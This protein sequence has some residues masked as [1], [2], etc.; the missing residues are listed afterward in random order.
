MR[1]ILFFIFGTLLTAILCSCATPPAKNTKFNLGSDDPY[2]QGQNL[3]EAIAHGSYSAAYRLMERGAPLNCQDKKDEWTPLT[4]AIYYHRWSIARV[5]IRAGANVNLADS[6]NRT[7][8][9]WSAMRNSLTTAQLLVEYGADI[10]AVDIGGRTALQYAI[11]YDNDSLAA[12]LA[13][14]GRIPSQ[15][16]LKEEQLARIQKEREKEAQKA[17][18]L[19]MYKKAYDLTPSKDSDAP[20]AL[21]S[22]PLNVENKSDM[23][24]INNNQATENKTDIKD[25]SNDKPIEK[26]EV[27][28][29]AQAKDTVIQKTELPQKTDKKAA[30]VTDK[31]T[32]PPNNGEVVAEYSSKQINPTN[33]SVP[34]IGEPNF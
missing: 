20:K 16:R 34:K 9:M 23:K 14:A 15:K 17:Q 33:T 10:N 18:N 6:A 7:P 24:T 22:K 25:A 26:K 8:L 21:Q 30:P 31:K 11:I 12:Y 13:E 19:K 3:I 29:T 1:R 4:Y 27:E 5:L 32:N 2:R 28:D